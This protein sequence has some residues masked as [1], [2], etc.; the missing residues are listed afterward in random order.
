[1]IFNLLSDKKNSLWFIFA[2]LGLNVVTFLNLFAEN[3]I[4]MLKIPS[5]VEQAGKGTTNF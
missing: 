3:Y 4:N 5:F 1:L 2:E